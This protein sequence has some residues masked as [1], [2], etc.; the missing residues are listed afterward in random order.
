MPSKS[1]ETIPLKQTYV[2]ELL[3]CI[4]KGTAEIFGT[5]SGNSFHLYLFS[6]FSG[7]QITIFDNSAKIDAKFQNTP[8]VNT[9]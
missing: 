5:S 9:V 3:Y 6:C 1:H 8:T 7:F 4:L 2:T